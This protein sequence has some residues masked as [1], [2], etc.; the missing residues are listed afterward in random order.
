MA[1]AFSQA[2]A[3]QKVPQ[4]VGIHRSKFPRVGFTVWA[5]NRARTE[6]ALMAFEA[7]LVLVLQLPPSA[8]PHNMY[9]GRSA[10][11]LRLAASFTV[12]DA[13]RRGC[14]PRSGQE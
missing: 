1:L 12:K 11:T 2:F 9:G 7:E 6:A 14:V 10:A 3:N 5:R 8:V 13:A 4:E